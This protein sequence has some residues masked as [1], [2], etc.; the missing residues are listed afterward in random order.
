MTE[1]QPAPDT[2]EKKKKNEEL[3]EKQTA[4]GS[5]D[6]LSKSSKTMLQKAPVTAALFAANMIVFLMLVFS[7]AKSFRSILVPAEQTLIDWSANYGPLTLGGEPWRIVSNTFLHASILHLALNL[8]V[9]FNLGPYAE[10]LLGSRRMFALY[11]LSGVTGSLSSLIWNPFN[12][13]AGASGALFGLFGCFVEESV[14]GSGFSLKE[15]LRPARVILMIAVVISCVYG[16]FM[17]GI[18]NAAHLGGFLAGALLSNYFR[19]DVKL[20][21]NNRD[22]AAVGMALTILIF[23]TSAE[24]FWLRSNSQFLAMLDYQNAL[25]LLKDKKY[26]EALT[27]LNAA[28]DRYKDFDVFIR[29]ANALFKLGRFE[30]ALEDCDNALSLEPDNPEGYLERGLIHHGQNNEGLAI[31]DINKALQLD[32]KNPLAYNNRAWSYACLGSWETAIEDCNKALA[33]APDLAVVLDTRGLCYLQMGETQLAADDL[34]KAMK[35][36]PEDGAAYFH[37]AL[38]NEKLGKA[39]EAEAN[40]LEAQRLRYEPE[41]W[42]TS[43]NAEGAQH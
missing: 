8:Y 34:R 22:S 12:V 36:A 41:S 19:Q 23:G 38:V 40:R 11:M 27:Y 42:E 20:P 2:T 37:M 3:F 14:L 1:D 21:W 29:R 16:A 17:P 26:Q 6:S 5:F 13:S 24:Y 15:V 25:P 39:K 18:D 43:L 30:D 7:T 31:E 10:S 33:I 4:T 32:D 28:A 9:L 35:V